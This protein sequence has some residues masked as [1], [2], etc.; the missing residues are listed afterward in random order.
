MTLDDILK[1]L[2]K[3]H[4]DW[5]N[6]INRNI[7]QR[8]HKTSTLL[9]SFET[10]QHMIARCNN[11]QITWGN[12]RFKFDCNMDEVVVPTKIERLLTDVHRRGIPCFGRGDRIFH[13]G[14][15]VFII[16]NPNAL[17]ECWFGS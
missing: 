6:C 12:V 16:R 5:K 15:Y 3:L 11:E 8:Y 17:C 9:G 10:N 2:T 14:L 1:Q 13:Q 7:P 4:T